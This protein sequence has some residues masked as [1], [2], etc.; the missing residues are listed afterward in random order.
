MFECLYV[1]VQCTGVIFL[2]DLKIFTTNRMVSKQGVQ[3]E[4]DVRLKDKKSK[5]KNISA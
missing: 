3:Y 1:Q 5:L 4:K 2:T